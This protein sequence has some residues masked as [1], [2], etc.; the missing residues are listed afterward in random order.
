MR[1][2]KKDGKFDLSEIEVS[3]L[4]DYNYP[5][6]HVEKLMPKLEEI[7]FL[8]KEKNAV[9]LAHLYQIP[10]IQLISDFRGDS[11]KLAEYAKNIGDKSLIVSST[12]KFMAEMAKILSP[13]KKVVVPSLEASCSI[14]EGINGETIKRIK[15]SFPDSSI[16]SY[17]NTYIDSK[18]EVDSVCTSANARQVLEN[19]GGNSVILLP[20][21]FFS[22]NV[23]KSIKNPG[24]KYFAY[25]GISNGNII[26]ED[27]FNEKEIVVSG[28]GINLPLLKKGTCIVHEDFT[29][30]EV[31]YLRKKDKI[32]VVMSHPEV[33]PEVARVSDFVGGTSNMINFVKEN[34][35]KLKYLVITEC[36]LTG[37]LRE[38]YR[39]TNFYTPCK[40]CPYMKKNSVDSL[41]DS[42]KKEVYEIKIE[43]TL[44]KKGRRSLDKMFELTG[45]LK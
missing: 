29:P 11:L 40:L 34:G 2:I 5:K 43:E 37:P 15:E 14:A 33:S 44:L 4:Y 23:I 10:P 13:S 17:I 6:E 16:V 32:D 41:I 42:L 21:Y 12:V 24:R 1:L 39:K 8:R 9:V 28:E 7:D 35:E 45:G 26:I 3:L 36:D 38:T 30:E 20:D 27:V 31:I 19:I 25:K 18:A 22:K